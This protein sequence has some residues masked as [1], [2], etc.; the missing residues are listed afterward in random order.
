MTC[1]APQAMKVY[2]P[3]P[4]SVNNPEI[5]PNSFSIFILSTFKCNTWKLEFQI[6]MQN[7]SLLNFVA[8]WAKGHI[9]KENWKESFW[10]QKLSIETFATSKWIFEISKYRLYFFF[11]RRFRLCDF[12]FLKSVTQDPCSIYV[13]LYKLLNVYFLFAKH[14]KLL[15]NW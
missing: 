11:K 3:R 9:S 8:W 1:I 13:T 14:S 5:W 7:M 15:P 6:S 4:C 2:F 10:K 12:F